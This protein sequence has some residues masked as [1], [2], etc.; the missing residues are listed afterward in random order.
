[1]SQFTLCPNWKST[2]SGH[3]KRSSLGDDHWPSI[4]TSVRDEL[5]FLKLFLQTLDTLDDVTRLLESKQMVSKLKQCP[6]E[7]F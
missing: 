4:C 5:R 6:R 2:S 7:V 3:S 1:M